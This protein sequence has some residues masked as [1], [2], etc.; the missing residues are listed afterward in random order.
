MS[1]LPSDIMDKDVLSNEKIK[2]RECFILL[3]LLDSLQTQVTKI[4]NY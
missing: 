1:F 4:T 3:K 2:R